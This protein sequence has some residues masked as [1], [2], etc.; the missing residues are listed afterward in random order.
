MMV[1][2]NLEE[3]RINFSS[4]FL[5]IWV[6]LWGV[7]FLAQGTK[8]ALFGG[9]IIILVYLVKIRSLPWSLILI[10]FLIFTFGFVYSILINYYEDYSLIRGYRDMFLPISLYLIGF[11]AIYTNNEVN[12]NTILVKRI[13]IVAAFSIFIYGSLNLF[14]HLYTH[15]EIVFYDRQI[16][17][18]W[19][20]G[21][22]AATTQGS[23]F[24]LMSAMLP[25][26]L[27]WVPNKNEKNISLRFKTL[28]IACVLISIAAT[29][30]MANRTLIVILIINFLICLILF[31]IL[32]KH[33]TVRII[34]I[35]LLLISLFLLVSV[36]YY[37]DLFGIQTFYKSSSLYA[38]MQ[39]VEGNFITE[40]SRITAWLITLYGLFQYPM[41][42]SQ[43]PIGLS[44][45]HNLWL[46]VAYTTGIVPFILIICITISYLIFY[47]RLIRSRWIDNN[48]KIL[49]T[50]VTISVLLNCMVEP[51]LGGHYILFMIFMLQLGLMH[52]L[53]LSKK[54]KKVSD[55]RMLA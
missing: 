9:L 19:T 26:V 36:F 43:S 37:I 35:I 27:L 8:I 30:I 42:G 40:N 38:R 31:F 14:V 22:S 44:A 5:L 45:P 2:S 3:V 1:R 23:R 55:L 32:N 33:K 46:D 39:V 7:N 47:V 13:L 16:Y 6:A 25:L 34:K 17:D 51:I 24:T 50:S 41:G 29:L 10:S 20:G 11:L 54:K 12:K 21:F 48:F 4:L 18:I 49:I 52:G 53:I 15:G 28:I